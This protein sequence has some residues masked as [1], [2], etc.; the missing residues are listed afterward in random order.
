[1]VTLSH[2]LRAGCLALAV[3]WWATPG[4]TAE[5]FITLASTTSTENSGLF[6][7]LLPLFE[8]E[9]GIAVRVIAVG[10]GQAMRLGQNGDA[11]LLL[12][13]HRPSEERFVADGYGS[14]RHDVMYN[15]FI[16]VGPATDPANIVGLASAAEAFNRIAASQAVFASRG[17]DS[18]THKAETGIWRQASVDPTGASGAWYRELGAGMGATLNAASAMDA[19]TLTDRATWLAFENPGELKLMVEGDPLLFNQYGVIAINPER[20]PH[21]KHQDAGRFV[22]W[23]LSPPGQGAIGGFR[24]RGTQVFFPNAKS[25][26]D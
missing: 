15:D 25:G 14:A 21:V 6:D 3:A 5:R 8:S 17:D 26:S 2:W 16:V 1:V 9:T 12:V 24:L 10:T 19:Y 7:H 22:E 18:G 20:H 23:L 4:Q 13:H 11:D